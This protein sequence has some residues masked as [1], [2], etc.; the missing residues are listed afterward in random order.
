MLGA[1]SWADFTCAR[2]YHEFI[3]NFACNV[4]KE[5]QA[6]SMSSSVISATY[7]GDFIKVYVVILVLLID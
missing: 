1:N 3:I 6:L 5:Q 4:D 2:K 7:L